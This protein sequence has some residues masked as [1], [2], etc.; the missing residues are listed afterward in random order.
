MEF[1]TGRFFVYD[2]KWYPAGTPVIGPGNRS[3]RYGDGLFETMKMSHGEIINQPFH[4]ERLFKGLSMLE[5]DIPAYFTAA[6]LDKAIRQL[7]EKNKHTASARIRLMV[8]RGD[9]GVFDPQDLRPHFI[10]ESW[11]LP[12]VAQLN[13][14]GLVIDIF[15]GCQKNCDGYANLKSN[16]YLPYVMAG[17]FARK[18]QWNDCLVLNTAGRICDSAIANVFLINGHRIVTPPLSEGCVAGVMRRWMLEKFARQPYQVAEE[19]ISINDLLAADEV[20][21]TNAV[22]H[23][24]WVKSFREKTYPPHRSK[25]IYQ[26]ILQ[27][28]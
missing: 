8:A 14:N 11:S 1:M 13:D 23:L 15:T 18:N 28:I 26:H 10:A 3:L 27:T 12:Q 6:F 25:E 7:A 20:F 17:L 16:N 4:F 2:N 21:L 24:R 22:F 19:P 9:G 5:F